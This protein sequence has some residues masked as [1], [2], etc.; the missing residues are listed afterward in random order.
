[1]KI[2]PQEGLDRICRCM[3]GGI[4]NV[5]VITSWQLFVWRRFQ[6]CLPDVTQGRATVAWSEL[7]GRRT[8]N[9]GIANFRGRDFSR[10]RRDLLWREI[11]LHE[12]N[13]PNLKAPSSSSLPAAAH[14][15]HP[16]HHR[17][18]YQIQPLLHQSQISAALPHK[19]STHGTKP[20]YEN[21]HTTP[22][23]NGDRKDFSTS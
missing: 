10:R 8:S 11:Y 16:I 13:H 19:H 22:L 1:M 9:A 2:E 14:H 3:C 4:I 7:P 21:Q 15:D 17:D 5:L 18:P 12:N 6:G 20:G 23:E